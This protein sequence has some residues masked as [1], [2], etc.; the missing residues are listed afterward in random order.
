M[1][2]ENQRMKQEKEKIIVLNVES[3]D[4]LRETARMGEPK[5][6]APLMTF[7]KNRRARGSFTL[8]GPTQ[9]PC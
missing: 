4:T 3:L 2:L 7:D 8:K 6:T 5:E 9:S 1:R